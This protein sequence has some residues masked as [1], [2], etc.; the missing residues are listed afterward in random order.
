MPNMKTA[1]KKNRSTMNNVTI[2]NAIIEKQRQN[3]KNTYLFFADAEKCFYKLWLKDCLVE[4]EE[5]G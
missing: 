4:M 3:H 2:I 1:G 5:I